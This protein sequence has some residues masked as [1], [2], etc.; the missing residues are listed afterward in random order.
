MALFDFPF[1][2]SLLLALPILKLI[3]ASEAKRLGAMLSKG[4]PA[5]L[6]ARASGTAGVK[7]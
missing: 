3:S 5:V 2:F 7:V 4:W 1:R 6:D